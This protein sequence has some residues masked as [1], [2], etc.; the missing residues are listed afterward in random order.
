MNVFRYNFSEE[1]INKISLFAKANKDMDIENFRNNFENWKK[2][3]EIEINIEF[4]RLHELNYK[5]DL[6]DK[7][8]KSARYY[9]KNKE[10]KETKKRKKYIRFNKDILKN[11]DEFIKD[12]N[13]NNQKPSFVYKLFMNND[14]Y[15]NN[16]EKQ[17]QELINNKLDYNE[18]EE[19]FKKTF[20]NKLYQSKK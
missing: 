12:N 19:K 2:D 7:L 3:N 11:I 15:K 10:K 16:I 14:K 6:N 5:G 13:E 8:F 1:L 9:Y 4:R 20:K 17:Y 18:I